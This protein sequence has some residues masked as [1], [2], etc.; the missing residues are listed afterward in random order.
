M[1][2]LVG[3]WKPKKLWISG[4]IFIC[5]YIHLL[6]ISPGISISGVFFKIIQNKFGSLK[7]LSYICIINS[8]LNY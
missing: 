7:L 2:L 6:F 5:F 8:Q 3:L 4:K 1:N